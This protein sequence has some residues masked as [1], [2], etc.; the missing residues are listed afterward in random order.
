[1]ATFR[2]LPSNRWQAIIRRKDTPLISKSFLNKQDSEKWARSI[3][4]QLDQGTYQSASNLET[5]TIGEAIDRYAKEVTPLK[6]G[7]AQEVRRLKY[8]RSIF[9]NYKL[10][11]LKSKHL[12]E[13]RD[14]R[15]KA[16]VS[17]QTVIH[18]LNI[19]S[20]VFNIAR[21]EWGYSIENP[22]SRITK[23]KKA[24]GRTRR[25]EPGEYERL[26]QTMPAQLR[27]AVDFA[28]ETAMRRSELLS[29]RWQ[30]VNFSE[31]TALLGSTKNGESRLVPLSSRALAILNELPKSDD[32]IFTLTPSSLS[33]GFKRAALKA[34]IQNLCLHDL[35]HEATSRLFERGLSTMETS[36]IT[37]HKSLGML[38]RY[39]HLKPHELAI[40]LG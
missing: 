33:H 37:G 19:V 30:D 20:H 26:L 12:A 10:G 25:L 39:T 28:I 29:L 13:H 24:S 15:L 2:R 9:G 7:A 35:R 31:R 23:P 21:N 1:M 36:A 4:A 27:Y 14:S 8:L 16:G 32:C 11:D 17:G 38:R 6:K 18:E 22:V 34:G 40:K 3:E 5:I